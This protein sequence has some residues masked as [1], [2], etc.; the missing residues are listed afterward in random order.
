MYLPIHLINL[1]TCNCNG[2]IFMNSQGHLIIEY[3]IEKSR[4]YTKQAGAELS[5]VQAGV[6]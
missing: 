5:S 3:I 2:N 1:N 4:K 6:S